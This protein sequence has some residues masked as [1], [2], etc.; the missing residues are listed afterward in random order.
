MIDIAEKIAP[1]INRT[2]LAEAKRLRLDEKVAQEMTVQ[3]VVFAHSHKM[4]GEELKTAWVNKIF[5]DARDGDLVVRAYVDAYIAKY[6]E[7]LYTRAQEQGVDPVPAIR[8]TEGLSQE[9]AEQAVLY[10]METQ[11][12]EESPEDGAD[13]GREQDEE[14][15]EPVSGLALPAMG[16]A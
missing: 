10:L 7:P 14:S 9:S 5:A 6:I 1:R 2:A 16:A 13:Q 11:E 8:A 4:T 3:A 12:D 15:E